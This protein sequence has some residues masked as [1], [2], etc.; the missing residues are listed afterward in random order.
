M[1]CPHFLEMDCS[2][3]LGSWMLRECSAA[4]PGHPTLWLP[5]SSPAR[6]F[7]LPLLPVLPP[8]QELRCIS[9]GAW[10]GTAM[11][12]GL[13]LPPDTGDDLPLDASSSMGRTEVFLGL[14][15]THLEKLIELKCSEPRDTGRTKL[16]GRWQPGRTSGTRKTTSQL[17]DC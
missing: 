5:A 3:D 13:V 8:R 6:G 14:S 15:G 9:W 10:T 1:G 2:V 16:P 7:F 11:R 4:L 12:Q 17:W